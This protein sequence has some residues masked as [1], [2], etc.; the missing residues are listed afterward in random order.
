MVPCWHMRIHFNAVLLVLL[1]LPSE[2]L[3]HALP[4]INL[5]SS[6]RASLRFS[7]QAGLRLLYSDLSVTFPDVPTW[8][9]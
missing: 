2:L 5:T 4:A 7:R 1:K 9:L 3:E 6:G 8:L